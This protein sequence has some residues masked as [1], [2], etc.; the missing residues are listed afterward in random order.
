MDYS[1]TDVTDRVDLP[2]PY[3][4]VVAAFET[5][6]WRQLGR[7]A[8]ELS[9]QEAE[10]IVGGYAEPAR[11]EF[12]AHLPDVATVLTSPDGQ[13]D[14]FV[15]WFWSQPAVRLSSVLADGTLVE[16]SRLWTRKPPWPRVLRS[17]WAGMDVR[18]ELERSSVPTRGRSVRAVECGD[19]AD[20]AAAA[21]LADAHRAHVVERGSPSTQFASIA[22]A[23]AL[24]R[25]AFEHDVRVRQRVVRA[26]S[27]LF[28]LAAVT[29]GVVSGLAPVLRHWS[30]IWVLLASALLVG[31]ASLAHGW[32]VRTV[33]YVRWIRPG[34]R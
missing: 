11:S 29:L 6:G 16:T 21:A 7:Y 14:A 19:L 31:A 20:P 3:P 17:G 9:E 2:T 34:F 1:Y 30:W 18:R 33:S 26:V 5:I 25:R 32:L 12:A 4:E 23:I 27:G 24:R 22:D 28:V 10:Q 8:L 15:S 13:A